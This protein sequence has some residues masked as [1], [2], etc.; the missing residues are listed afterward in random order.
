MTAP[1]LSKIDRLRA[2]DGDGCWL[3]GGP[4]DFEAPPNTKSAPTKEHLQPL[5]AG[6]TGALDNLVL[7]HPGCNRQ[8][9]DRSRTDKERMRARRIAKAARA[10]MPKPATRPAGTRSLPVGVKLNLDEIKVIDWRSV[11]SSAIAAALFFAGLALGL[12]LG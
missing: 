12:L 6:G 1:A 7:C 10:T 5:S 9:G 11:A 8:L 3:C 4:L 2:R